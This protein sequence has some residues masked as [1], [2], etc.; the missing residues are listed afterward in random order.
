MPEMESCTLAAVT[1]TA[2][3]RQMVSVTMLR[4]RPTIFLPA[5]MPWLVASTLVEVFTLC[6]S[7]TQVDGS[8]SR[9]SL[10]RKSCLSRP[11]SWVNTPSCCHLAK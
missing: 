10:C 2:S 3:R 8:A 1:S 6:A 5:S 9:P 7:I 11:L 4:F